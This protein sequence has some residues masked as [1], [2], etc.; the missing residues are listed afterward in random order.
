VEHL[1]PADTANSC[2]ETFE[3]CFG[4]LDGIANVE[5]QD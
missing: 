1:T 5:L 2:G 4:E 3:L